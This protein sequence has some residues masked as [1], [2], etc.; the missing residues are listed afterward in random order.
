MLRGSC[1]FD[2]RLL[3]NKAFPDYQQWKDGEAE[4]DWRDLITASIEAHLIAVR[5]SEEAPVSREARKGE[6]QIIVQEIMR[7][8]ASRHER[9][10]AW[11][12]RTG[13]SEWAFYRRSAEL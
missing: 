5:H 4:S 1:P 6:E 2:L 9:I 3:V 10:R 13:K 11:M 12:E 8:H 7:D